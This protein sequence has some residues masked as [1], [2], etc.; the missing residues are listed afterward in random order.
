[1]FTERNSTILPM[2]KKTPSAYIGL[3]STQPLPNTLIKINKNIF[4]GTCFQPSPKILLCSC[5]FSKTST[6]SQEKMMFLWE[7]SC[8][9]LCTWDHHCFGA[10]SLLPPMMPEK[11]VQ[12]RLSLAFW[13]PNWCE[14]LPKWNAFPL[15]FREGHVCQEFLCCFGALKLF[16]NSKFWWAL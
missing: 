1:M 12:E 15:S 9:T 16:K 6:F 11:D 14:L 13:V 8:G 2:E 10:P 7:W 3:P 4:H 5:F